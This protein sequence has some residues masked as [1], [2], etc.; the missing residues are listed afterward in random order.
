[1]SHPL[2]LELAGKTPAAKATRILASDHEPGHQ[3]TPAVPLLSLTSD[4]GKPMTLSWRGV[5]PQPVLNGSRAR[6]VNALT[7]TDLVVQ[8]TRT[9]F[10]QSL[11]LK[12]RSAVEANG[13]VTLTLR[14][15]GL[16]ANVG[17]DR[18]VSF[19]DRTGKHVAA[20]QAPVMWD[21]RTD[22][23]TGEHTRVAD[24]GLKVAQSGDDV[25]LT[26][27]PDA[28]FLA[29]PDTVFP[30]T[31]DP[32]VNLGTTFDAFVQ[33]GYTTDQSAATELKLG[34]NGAGQIARSF[35]QF[36]TGSV[37]GR[38]ILGAKFNL[39]NHHS[40]TCNSAGS[41]SWEVWRSGTVNTGT[42]WTPQPTWME[43]YATSTAT[44]GASGCA[45]GWV[46]AD[47]TSMVQVWAN[48]TATR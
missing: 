37:Q 41:G 3:E 46:S 2:D 31:V 44:K 5:L 20:L 25:D 48:H 18:S 16:T 30:V 10:E 29:A 6:Y 15:P 9:G 23:R 14:A 1:M 4:D 42:R 39:W 11:E 43:K 12:D 45:A 28:E 27:T 32:A 17:D 40:W 26:L 22:P 38:K 33:Q 8:T 21:A 34:Y 35:L 19:V 24:V 13:S 36:K 47:I 7:A